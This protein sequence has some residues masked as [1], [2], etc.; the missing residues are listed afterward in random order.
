MRGSRVGGGGGAEP[1]SQP[2]KNHK[3]IGLISNTGPDPKKNHK[4]TK[5]DSMWSH[6]GHASETTFKLRFAGGP[7]GP[8]LVGNWILPSSPAKKSCQS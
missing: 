1:L 3:N 6:H 8:L 5:P 4:T 2:L 7:N